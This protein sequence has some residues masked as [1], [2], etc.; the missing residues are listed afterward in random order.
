MTVFTT[1]KTWDPYIIIKARDMIKL[2]ARSTP[3]EQVKLSW[4]FPVQNKELACDH[5]LNLQA[6]RVLEDGMFCDI[7][8]IRSF[9]RNKERFIRRRQRILGPGGATLKVSVSK[10]M[11]MRG[12]WCHRLL[13]WFLQAIELLTQCY[14][15]VQGNTVS[16]LG[17]HKGLKQVIHLPCY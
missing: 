13:G 17:P 11:R 9:V 2:L 4:V 10:S 8:K 5:C 15:L 14:V 7:I 3:Y 6:T 1:R 12:T 16:A